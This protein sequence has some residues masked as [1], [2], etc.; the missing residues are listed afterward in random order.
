MA[1][2]LIADDDAHVIRIMS[3]WLQ[4]HGHQVSEVRNGQKALEFLD[5]HEVDFIISDINMPVMNGLELLQ[6]VR[7]EKELVM[8]FLLISSRC[9][10]KELREVVTPLNAR[11]Y[12]KPFVPS[13]L[14][15]EIDQMLMAAQS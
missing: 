6:A 11:V 14:V 9:D 10:Q 12:P 1:R 5:K 4:R 3:L 15:S 8:P 2:I 13:K 7:K